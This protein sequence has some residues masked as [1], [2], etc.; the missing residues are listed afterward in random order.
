MRSE[1]TCKV[2]PRVVIC[3]T[4]ELIYKYIT[5]YNISINEYNIL[6]YFTIN[7][8]YLLLEAGETWLGNAK[9][10][11]QPCAIVVWK[12]ISNPQIKGLKPLIWGHFWSIFEAFLKEKKWRFL[13]Y[14]DANRGK[15]KNRGNFK[16]DCSARWHLTGARACWILLNVRIQ[17]L[18]T[19]EIECPGR[20]MAFMCGPYRV[21]SRFFE[22]LLN[23]PGSVLSYMCLQ[24]NILRKRI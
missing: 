7:V 3:A 9:D 22:E 20:W 14:F 5:M 19:N 23:P 4:A 24:F 16:R 10:C 15:W 21:G 1:Y 13:A 2:L 12:K 11:I 17:Y 18:H 6:F 8:I